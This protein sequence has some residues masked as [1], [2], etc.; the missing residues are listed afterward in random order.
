M[1][2]LAAAIET[3]LGGRPP[4]LDGKLRYYLSNYRL[5]TQ[6]LAQLAEDLLPV[7]VK[8]A[9][10]DLTVSALHAAMLQPLC[11][12]IAEHWTGAVEEAGLKHPALDF[13]LILYHSSCPDG[14]S[15]AWCFWRHNRQVECVGMRYNQPPPDVKGRRVAV[16]DFS[17]PRPV[18]EQMYQDAALL[19]V[20]DH[21]ETA[22]EHLAGLDYCHF[23]MSKAGCELAWEALENDK[24]KPFFLQANGDHDVWR[25]V[26]DSEAISRVLR[27][28]RG[29]NF[30]NYDRMYDC[31]LAGK[32]ECREGL[33]DQGRRLLEQDAK[34]ITRQLKFS[35]L[36]KLKG[37]DY[38][39]RVGVPPAQLRSEF[40]EAMCLAGGCDFSC[41][42]IYALDKG[43]WWLSARSVGKKSNV[44]KI[45]EDQFGGGGHFNA[46]GATLY[47]REKGQC[48]SA[49]FEPYV[50]PKEI[51][52][53]ALV[54]DA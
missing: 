19:R 2:K 47:E 34:A 14:L 5:K 20:W 42:Y 6:Q 25:K 16:V 31:E 39:V 49:Y 52:V 23:D 54:A 9:M 50:V 45:M 29:N 11:D 26:P 41:S 24:V 10:Q 1:E 48:F 37:T 51:P 7:T 30:E 15:A 36:F 21:H 4:M 32:T 17:F 44:A 18:L 38:I 40:G 27:E 33:L 43:E 3:Y 13:D 12:L 8:A 46:A 35:C 28:Q 53:E 22:L